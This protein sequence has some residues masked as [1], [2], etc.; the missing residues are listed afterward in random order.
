MDFVAYII[1]ELDVLISKT[2]QSTDV[3]KNRNFRFQF[4]NCPRGLFHNQILLTMQ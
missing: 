1:F 3:N 2:N 4:E